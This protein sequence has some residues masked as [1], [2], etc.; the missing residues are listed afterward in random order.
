MTRDLAMGGAFFFFFPAS[1]ASLRA[2]AAA[3]AASGSSS[4]SPKRSSSSSSSLGGSGSFFPFPLPFSCLPPAFSCLPPFCFPPASLAG[5]AEAY[6]LA[7]APPCILKY[8]AVRATIGNL[9]IFPNQAAA[10]GMAF[11]KPA[12]KVK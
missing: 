7:G 5:A 12:S 6:G 4:S 3:A 1:A 10:C 11:K 2:F 8:P 9:A